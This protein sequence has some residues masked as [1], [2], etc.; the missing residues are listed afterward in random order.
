MKSTKGLIVFNLI[1]ILL[2]HSVYKK[3]FVSVKY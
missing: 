3:N 1:N 2:D